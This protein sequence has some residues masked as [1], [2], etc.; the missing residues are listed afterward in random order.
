MSGDQARGVEAGSVLVATSV[1]D[2]GQVPEDRWLVDALTHQG[3]ASRLAAWDDPHENWDAGAVVIRSTWGYQHRLAAF[4]AWLDR[5]EPG[6]QNPAAMV[7]ANIDKERQFAWLDSAGI[8]RVRSS[9]VRD[10]LTAADLAA[11]AASVFPDAAG[12]VMK[13][14]ISASGHHTLL[15]DPHRRPGRATARF[16]DAERLV[17]EVIA[18]PGRGAVLLQPFH[19]EID[20][21][22]LALVYFGGSFS[23]AFLRFPAVF[24]ARARAD[25]VPHPPAA[26][27]ALA[28][29]ILESL[30]RTPTYARIDLIE[31]G[32]RPVVMEVELAEPG[33][34]LAYL[35]P[36]NRQRALTLF[37]RAI[38]RA[39]APAMSAAVRP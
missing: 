15:L 20:D 31:V 3:V 33:L 26:A 14:T 13:P 22:E 30:P 34:G 4:H 37:A 7:R 29:R 2:H 17:S 6:V 28:D 35:P 18:R 21:G 1:K 27:L 8:P 11:L 39:A 36:E 10:P 32:G 5:V 25:H 12:Y 19:P 24:R 38:V 9:L 16:S 23:H